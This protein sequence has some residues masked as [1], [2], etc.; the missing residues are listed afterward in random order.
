LDVLAR[1]AVFVAVLVVVTAFREVLGAGTITLGRTIAVAP[2]F[3]DPARA[4]GLGGGAL[5]CL[6]YAAG[7]ARLLASRRG[8]AVQGRDGAT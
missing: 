6:G 4:V 5:I 2:F 8:P 7:G 1:A 3:R